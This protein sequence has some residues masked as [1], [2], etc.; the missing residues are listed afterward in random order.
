MR[1]CLWAA[2]EARQQIY[3]VRVRNTALRVSHG[4][5]LSLHRASRI[6]ETRAR[7]AKVFVHPF[8]RS[9][10]LVDVVD[11][12]VRDDPVIVDHDAPML[13]CREVPRRLREAD[14]HRFSVTTRSIFHEGKCISFRRNENECDIASKSVGAY[15]FTC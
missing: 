6:S 1:R 9:F 15:H 3:Q 4:S 5:L 10:H 11:L 2:S 13:S 8:L 7:Y 14:T 12:I